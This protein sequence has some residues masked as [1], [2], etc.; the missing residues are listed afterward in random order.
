MAHITPQQL[1]DLQDMFAGRIKCSRD[2]LATELDIHFPAMATE[3][4]RL[5]RGEEEL[6]EFLKAKGMIL[7]ELDPKQDSFPENI[8]PRLSLR[9]A[10]RSTIV[11]N[12]PGMG[13]YPLTLSIQASN[14]SD[15]PIDLIIG[16]KNP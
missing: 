5:W 2:S 7:E 16:L 1:T 13:M 4:Q 11:L 10:P 12:E 15:T 8:E 3:L 14:R 6:K 9:C